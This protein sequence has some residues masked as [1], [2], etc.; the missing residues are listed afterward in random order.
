MQVFMKRASMPRYIRI[1]VKVPIPPITIMAF[2]FNA[3]RFMYSTTNVKPKDNTV[4]E[5]FVPIYFNHH[6]GHPRFR[7]N[8]SISNIYAMDAALRRTANG[9]QGCH[10]LGCESKIPK[11]YNFGLIHANL[12]LNAAPYK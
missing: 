10:F 7:P 11:L 6:M 2:S 12:F 8:H 5:K 3:A 9:I 4:K 1:V